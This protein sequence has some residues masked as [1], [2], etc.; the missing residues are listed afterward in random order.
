MIDPK[1][2]FRAW[3]LKLSHGFVRVDQRIHAHQAPCLLGLSLIFVVC[4]GTF[5]ATS[6]FTGNELFTFHIATLETYDTIWKALEA[7]ADIHPPAYYLLAHAILQLIPSEHIALRA[8]ALAGTLLGSACIFLF[9]RRRAGATFGIVA[10]LLPFCAAQTKLLFGTA[11][12]YPLLFGFGMAAL[13]CWQ[14]SKESRGIVRALYCLGLGAALFMG[15]ASHYYGVMMLAALATGEIAWSGSRRRVDKSVWAALVAGGFALGLLWPIVVG[16]SKYG[17]GYHTRP[18]WPALL[19]VYSELC[20]L[21]ALPFVMA[22][23]FLVL[24]QFGRTTPA[25]RITGTKEAPPPAHEL[26]A[27]AATSAIPMA[28][29]IVAL[30]VTNAFDA[31]FFVPA[32]GGMAIL[33]VLQVST[34]AREPAMVGGVVCL[35]LVSWFCLLQYSWFKTGLTLSERSKSYSQEIAS[36]LEAIDPASNIPIAIFEAEEFL[37]NA[38]SWP[39]NHGS[40]LHYVYGDTQGNSRPFHG[41]PAL[42]PWTGLSIKE[43]TPFTTRHRQF[44]VHGDGGRY[45]RYLLDRLAAEA[46]DMKVRGLVGGVVVFEVRME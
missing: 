32:V 42:K 17:A 30:T 18:S 43:Y 34:R 6:P 25:D 19:Q 5:A 9:V 36:D 45:G 35:S 23:G 1:P 14:V 8:P 2:S 4:G 28:G 20:R 39:S 46:A 31:R 40:R 37:R 33:G 29:F 38:H 13:Y 3:L 41:V 11:R 24:L 15:I 16:A 10:L 44:L 26:V 12:G 21:D 27:L 22:L 7:G